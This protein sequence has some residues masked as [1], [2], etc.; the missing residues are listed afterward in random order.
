MEKRE[1]GFPKM[2]VVRE[3]HCK[4]TG[5]PAGGRLLSSQQIRAQST[6]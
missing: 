5:L 2:R 6:S 1:V 3:N 4:K